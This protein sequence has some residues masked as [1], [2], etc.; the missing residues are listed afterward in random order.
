MNF[1]RWIAEHGPVYYD[2]YDEHI[3]CFYCDGIEFINTGQQAKRVC[4]DHDKWTRIWHEP[5]CVWL[6]A[7]EACLPPGSTRTATRA[8][9]RC[10]TTSTTRV[11]ADPAGCAKLR[12]R[13]SCY[14]PAEGR[15]RYDT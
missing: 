9:T 7:I 14:H 3:S 1:A 11:R 13:S 8:D 6:L 5:D 15:E 4:V 12:A 2:D 10:V